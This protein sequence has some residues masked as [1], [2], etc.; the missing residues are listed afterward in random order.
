MIVYELLSSG[1]SKTRVAAR[2]SAA[3]IAINLHSWA[4]RVFEPHTSMTTENYDLILQELV[5]GEKEVVS[6]NSPIPWV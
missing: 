6:I 5:F 3:R 2:K 4:R 1:D